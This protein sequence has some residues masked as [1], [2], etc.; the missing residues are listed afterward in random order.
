MVIYLTNSFQFTAETTFDMLSAG[1]SLNRRRKS[2][3]GKKRQGRPKDLRE[4][5]ANAYTIVTEVAYIIF[6][7]QAIFCTTTRPRFLDQ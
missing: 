4:G 1:P 5:V 6:I 3:L 2:K 7:L